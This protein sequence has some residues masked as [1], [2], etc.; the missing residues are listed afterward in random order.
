MFSSNGFSC[1]LKALHKASQPFFISRF[2]STFW[3]F[4]FFITVSGS[5][6][7][8]SGSK[9]LLL[10]TAEVF[11]KILHAYIYTTLLLGYSVKAVA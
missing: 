3:S 9:T 7:R 1:R 6:F 8:E 11:G 2:L 4:L 5:Q 10:S